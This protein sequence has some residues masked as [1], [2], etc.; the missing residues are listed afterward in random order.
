VER[1]R[2]LLFRC[3]AG[4]ESFIVNEAAN[5]DRFA[6]LDPKADALVRIGA[7]L[8]LGASRGACQ[9]AVASALEAGACDEE[10]VATLIAV[11]RVIGNARVVFAAPAIASA[12]GYDIDGALES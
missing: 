1:K 2:H 4:D 11:A 3:A 6:A 5:G 10:I 7:T 12:L 8:A 9:S